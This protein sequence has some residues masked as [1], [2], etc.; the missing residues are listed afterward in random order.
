[1]W[2]RGRDICPARK[3]QL[4]GSPRHI[5]SLAYKDRVHTA[6]RYAYSYGSNACFCLLTRGEEDVYM[7]IRPTLLPEAAL[8]PWVCLAE[9]ANRRIAT[10]TRPTCNKE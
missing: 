8:P 4:P 7:C 2:L 3:D 5:V 6:D 1:M 9:R 10:K